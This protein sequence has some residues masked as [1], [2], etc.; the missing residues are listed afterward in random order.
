MR[1]EMRKFLESSRL[2]GGWQIGG[3]CRLMGQ[4]HIVHAEHDLEMRF[5]RERRRAYPGG[6]PGAGKNRA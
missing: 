5:L 1:A 2:P 3:D 4:P 6:V